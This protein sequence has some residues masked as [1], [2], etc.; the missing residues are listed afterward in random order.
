MILLDHMLLSGEVVCYD[1]QF[2][3]SFNLHDPV[4]SVFTSV[5]PDKPS[6]IVLHYIYIYIYI[7]IIILPLVC[8]HRNPQAL[9][10]TTSVFP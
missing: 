1:R 6:S 2:E 8:F 9:Y 7:Y 5:F 10:Y 3:H 4:G